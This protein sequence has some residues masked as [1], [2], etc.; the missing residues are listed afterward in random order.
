MNLYPP[1]TPP[2][3]LSS[4][5]TGSFSSSGSSLSMGTSGGSVSSSSSISMGSSISSSS[6][7]GGSTR[8]LSGGGG[9]GTGTHENFSPQVI[10]RLA[11]EVQ[12]LINS[13]PEG[14]TFVPND[15]ETLMEIHADMVGPVGTPYEEGIFRM[16]LVL[17]R[18]YPHS[19]PR[20]FFMNKIYHPNVSSCGDICV[21]FLKKD[22]NADLT[23]GHMLQ[24]RLNALCCS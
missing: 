11:R 24:V 3:L 23:I 4:A 7:A 19:P 14:I 18:H 5:S 20:A 16:R 8:R 17:S 1:V 22:W 15:E 6:I 10:Q 13:P 21:N 2:S 12:D 9:V